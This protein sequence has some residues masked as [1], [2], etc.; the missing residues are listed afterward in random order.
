MERMNQRPLHFVSEAP[1]YYG[2]RLRTLAAMA[3]FG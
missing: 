1:A 3:T 2:R